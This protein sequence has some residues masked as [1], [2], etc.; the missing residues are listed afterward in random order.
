MSLIRRS[1]ALTTIPI[2]CL[3]ILISCGGEPTAPPVVPPVTI[4]PQQEIPI[5]GAQVAGMES[6]EQSV[7]NLMK[8]YNVPGGAIAIVRNGKLF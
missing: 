4:P 1:I 8:K 3:G 2:A 6:Y 5:T 7:R